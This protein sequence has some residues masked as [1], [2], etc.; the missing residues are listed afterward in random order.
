MN[1]PLGNTDNTQARV[2]LHSQRSLFGNSHFRFG[3]YEFED[4]IS[5]V[6][7]IDLPAPES[8]SWYKYGNRIANRLALSYNTFI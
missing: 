8:K 1:H 5:L 2:L 4:I 7:S 6:D 3:L